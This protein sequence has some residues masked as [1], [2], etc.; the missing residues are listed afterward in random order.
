MSTKHQ[1]GAM[2]LLS[3]VLIAGC[4]Y[5]HD[6]HLDGQVLLGAESEPVAG[7]TITLF[8]GAMDYATTKTDAE[9]LWSMTHSLSDGEFELSSEKKR[10]LRIDDEHP[11]QIRIAF[12]DREVIAPFPRVSVSDM[13]H[14]IFASVLTIIDAEPQHNADT[15]N[16]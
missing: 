4:S 12:D 2:L 3:L 14:D 1:I 5:A 8:A 6:L 10:Q 16:H 11:Y 7:A 15:T 9:G 13:T